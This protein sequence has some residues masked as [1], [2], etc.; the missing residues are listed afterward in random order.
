MKGFTASPRLLLLA[1]LALPGVAPAQEAAPAAEAS[2]SA[3]VATGTD[4]AFL[5]G[6][7]NLPVALHERERGLVRQDLRGLI[8]TENVY[9]D[10]PGG[11]TLR[12]MTTLM[13]ARETSDSALAAMLVSLTDAN[14]REPGVHEV[15]RVD[16][17]GHAFHLIRRQ[18]MW[19]LEG[20]GA[21]APPAD[22]P[23]SQVRRGITL[24]GAIRNVIVRI[25]LRI[26]ASLEEHEPALA[27][28]LLGLEL[29]LDTILGQREALERAAAKPAA[30]GAHDALP[31]TDG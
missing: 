9:F 19:V 17:G 1:A 28:A 10:A 12:L 15:R 31:R 7:V 16:V 3:S 23:E 29:D 4:I 26:P 5:A 25:D 13:T 21:V 11:Q 18:P 30:S 6:R 2:T 20:T 14:A 24:T 22:D 8:S 27:E